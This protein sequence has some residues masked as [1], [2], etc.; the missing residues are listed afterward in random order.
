MSGSDDNILSRLVELDRKA[1]AMV[2]D[3]QETLDDTLANA[4]RDTARFREEYTRKAMERIGIIREEEGRA[5]EAELTG[6][7]QRYQA[8]M[9]G[10]EKTYQEH[11]VRWEEEIYQRCIQK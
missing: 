11:H 2:E 7:T 4:E 6:I 5:S 1:C 3:A 8:L 10:L 9:D